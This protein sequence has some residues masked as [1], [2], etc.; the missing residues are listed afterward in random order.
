MIISYKWIASA[1]KLTGLKYE[2]VSAALNNLGFEVNTTT[3]LKN[4]G[5]KLVKITHLKKVANTKNL[6]YCTIVDTFNKNY[7]VICGAN[8]LKINAYAIYGPVNSTIANG[9]KLGAKQ[10]KGYE[11]L[12]MLCSLSELGIN[13]DNIDDENKDGIF[14][15]KESCGR[16]LW[17]NPQI[18]IKDIFNDCLYDIDLTFNRSD[19]FAISQILRELSVYFGIQFFEPKIYKEKN[20]VITTNFLKLTKSEISQCEISVFGVNFR[21]Y[22]ISFEDSISM[23][24][25]GYKIDNSDTINIL[26]IQVA[27]ETGHIIIPID[28]TLIKDKLLITKFEINNK[29]NLVIKDNDKI[30]YI[31]GDALCSNKYKPSKSTKNILL[32]G[33]KPDFQLMRKLL[34]QNNINSIISDRLVKPI[35]L[36]TL[37]YAMDRLLYLINFKAIINSTV[38]KKELINNIKPQQS[39]N[40]DFTKI[41]KLLGFK[42]SDE[43]IIKI[44][45][46]LNFI[47]N[48]KSDQVINV[49]SND[50][51]LDIETEADIA[52]EIIRIYGYDKIV[53]KPY[54]IN[55]SNFI[56]SKKNEVA[57][58]INNLLSSTGF[59]EVKSYNL[60]S[61]D[62]HNKYN[63]LNI[64]IIIKYYIHCQIN[65]FICKNLIFLIYEIFTKIIVIINKKILKFLS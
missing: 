21:N 6:T 45:K 36:A 25:M 34:K 50:N 4:K 5:L 63:F 26:A 43:K 46:N 29:S 37:K 18:Q 22:A 11:S 60:V 12:G 7:N 42:L 24:H 55:H 33:I 20:N 54:K 30:I 35:S 41:S 17:N 40:V 59:F 64:K 38:S 51:R 2:R 53:S 48:K 3:I 14:L 19:A 65:M 56:P 27:L 1:L 15:L 23:L 28:S 57:N 9:T 58:F 32:I 47:V 10:I 13:E 39:I 62:Y 49:T 8:N 52:E 61:E 44:L 31:F 16:R